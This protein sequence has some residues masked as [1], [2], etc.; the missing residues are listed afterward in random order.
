MFAFRV[1]R[2]RNRTSRSPSVSAHR[3]PISPRWP[4]LGDSRFPSHGIRSVFN[5]CL[6]AQCTQEMRAGVPSAFVHRLLVLATALPFGSSN[7]SNGFEVI[8][9]AISIKPQKESFAISVSI[10]TATARRVVSGNSESVSEG[11]CR[12]LV[13]RR[14]PDPSG[15]TD[16]RSHLRFASAAT[17]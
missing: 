13:F 12:K 11:G 16:C 3:P 17:S 4:E 5:C 9:R 6:A 14:H 7:L 2:P 15:T 10:P 8:K 1:F